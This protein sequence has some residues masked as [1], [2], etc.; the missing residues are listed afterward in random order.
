MIGFKDFLQFKVHVLQVLGSRS[1]WSGRQIISDL[2][3][4]ISDLRSQI[5][6][7]RSQSAER[8]AQIANLKSEI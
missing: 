7:L 6:D 4:Q 2:R 5:S 3:S 1:Q 8:R